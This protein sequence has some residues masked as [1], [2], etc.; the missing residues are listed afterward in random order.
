MYEYKIQKEGFRKDGYYTATVKVWE[1]VEPEEPEE[2]NGDDQGE[3]DQG[4]DEQGEQ[5]EIQKWR[6]EVVYGKR[7]PSERFKIAEIER[8]IALLGVQEPTLEP[9]KSYLAQEVTE[10]L[11]AKGYLE[12][13]EEFAEDMPDVD[14]RPPEPEPEPEPEPDPDPPPF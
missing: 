4:E 10:V 5:E 1:K 8:R 13:W 7:V 2:P 12:V 3:D 6:I 14:N 11:Q 9:E